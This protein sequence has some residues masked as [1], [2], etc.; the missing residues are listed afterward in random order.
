MKKLKYIIEMKDNWKWQIANSVTN[1]EQLKSELNLTDEE[2]LD[3]KLLPNLPIRIT[4]Y[5][6]DLIK[7]NEI[8]KKT[9]IPSSK[10]LVVSD[11][12]LNDPL[13][14][15]QY[16]KTS[17]LIQKYPK[18]V[19][20]TVTKQ[21]GSFCRYC[22]RSRIVGN[23]KNYNK[24]DWEESFEY[25]RNN[26]IT[27]VLISGGDA[28][29]LTNSQIDFLLDNLTQIE[30]VDII[31]IGTKLPVV[32]PYRVDYELVDILKKYNKIKPIYINIHVSHPAEITNDF[33]EVCN[34]LSIEAN[35]ILGSQTVLLKGVNDDAEVLQ[36]LFNKLLKY[37]VLPYYLYQMD[38]INGGEHFRCSLD[39][40]IEIMKS[41][42]SYNSGRALPE[43]VVD[44]EIG[45][46]PLRLDYVQRLENGKYIL[47][48]FEK[49]KSIEY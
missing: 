8:L 14:E 30:N 29:M 39:K 27:D 40:M 3:L 10:E 33:I 20:F 22:T 15:E 16:R 44:S 24:T 28:L 35:C 13:F 32:L 17:C 19:L 23:S 2:M 18:R 41:L 47:T 21:C 6:I 25:I 7:K 9:V 12:E 11:G 45:K 36:E 38:K 48:S 42:I 1:V 26:N 49:N 5:Y 43:F 37:R 31:R 46:I 34:K 4:P